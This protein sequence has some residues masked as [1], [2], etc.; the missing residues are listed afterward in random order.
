MIKVIRKRK[1]KLRNSIIYVEIKKNLMNEHALVEKFV[2]F[3]EQC[4]AYVLKICNFC[5]RASRNLTLSESM[6]YTLVRNWCKFTYNPPLI[7][8]LTL[9]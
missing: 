1:K 7:G 8:F 5:S 6:K 9:R 2:S 3:R 4:S